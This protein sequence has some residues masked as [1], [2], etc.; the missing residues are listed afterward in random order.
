[1]FVPRCSFLFL[2]SVMWACANLLTHAST[3][4]MLMAPEAQA[5]L[6]VPR[7]AT[8]DVTSVADSENVKLLC[9]A[10]Q[11]M[12]TMRLAIGSIWLLSFLRQNRVRTL[13]IYHP[14]TPRARWRC[15]VWLRPQRWRCETLLR[16]EQSKER[17][18]AI[19]SG[20]CFMGCPVL[21]A[22]SLLNIWKC[23]RTVLVRRAWVRWTLGV[24]FAI[25]TWR[26]YLLNLFKAT[27]FFSG[28]H[29]C[30]PRDSHQSHCFPTPPID[31]SGPQALCA[32]A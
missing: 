24:H 30:W 7:F 13:R 32:P 3:S 21:R 1:M 17:V 16:P 11:R 20:K 5:K 15:R 29:F 4:V 10:L 9:H 2:R 27:S 6:S 8:V 19:Q 18:W 23:D 25:A 22:F 28:R 31:V 14:R 26:L 12:F